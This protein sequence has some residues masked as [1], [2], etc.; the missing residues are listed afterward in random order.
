MAR[1]EQL[2]RQHKILQILEPSR[3]GY[4]LE[5]IRD[6]L[7]T[8]LGLT[9]LHV[10][11]VRRDLEALQ[12]AGVDVDSH[13]SPRGRVW[14]MGSGA[15]GMHKIN[16]SA[17][18]LIALSLGRDL[19]LPLAGTP[20]WIGIESFW[21]KIQ[22][23]LP[24]SIWDHYHK[25]RQ[26][27]H[28]SGITPK[29]YKEQEGVL[30]TINRA[31]QQHRVVQISY[32]TLGQ[33]MPK[34]REI[35]PYGVVLYQSSIYIVAAAREVEDPESRVRHWKLD[36]FKKA[37]ALDDYFK[38]PKDFDLEQ[39]LAQSIGIFASEKP[40]NFK[41]R[42]SSFAA[43][44]VRED[45]WHPEQK[46]EPQEDGSVI[47]TVKAANDLEIIPRVLALGPEAEVLSPASCRKA[48]AER[49]KRLAEIYK[50]D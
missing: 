18:E 12:A 17:T 10:R 19:M 1:N 39:H 43:A 49:V 21:N 36:R 41:I 15:R 11:T 44:W 42:I 33:P 27:L 6:D 30:K 38:P 8:Q 26:V 29:S 5:E 3:Y 9:S 13:E 28:V 37:E 34:Q 2:I 22:E 45:P 50:I 14:K 7:V 24:G 32:Q 35:E 47:L 48:V 40:Q 46:I 4:L 31:I 20:F 25:Y 23:E 16:A